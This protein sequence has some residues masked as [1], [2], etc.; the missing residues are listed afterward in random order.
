[1]VSSSAAP[2][3][4]TIT[5]WS[6][7]ALLMHY[8]H[9]PS[10]W[11]VF[12]FVAGAVAAFACLWLVGRGAIEGAQP[13]SQGSARVLAGA[14]DIFAVGLAVGAATLIAMIPAWI[15]WPMASF[16]ATTLYLV[17]ASVQL[18]AAQRRE[19]DR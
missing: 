3:G 11:E 2:Y 10:V 6:S 1:M 17:T 16:V 7:G 12:L 14:L 8:R 5:V 13:F 9:A 18:A 4:Y 15:A 19:R